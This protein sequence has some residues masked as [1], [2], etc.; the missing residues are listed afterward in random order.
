MDVD[1]M[2]DELEKMDFEPR[3]IARACPQNLQGA[4]VLWFEEDWHANC[5]RVCIDKTQH[6]KP[7]SKCGQVRVAIWKE[8]KIW[9]A[10]DVPTRIQ[11]ALGM[12]MEA[13]PA[14]QERKCSSGLAV[15]P[16]LQ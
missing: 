16:T 11:N 6:L 10:E 1:Q 4:F 13:D 3:K 5:F 2:K 12:F 9:T 14:L 8:G 7:S 15:L